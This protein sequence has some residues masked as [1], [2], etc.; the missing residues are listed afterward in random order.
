[1][2]KTI[3]TLRR[4]LG[5]FVRYRPRPA[6]GKKTW[7]YARLTEEVSGWYSPDPENK[8][9]RE[10]KF[11][12]FR[13]IGEIPRLSAESDV[14]EASKNFAEFEVS[15][16]AKDIGRSVTI[17]LAS[18]AEIKNRQFF[19]RPQQLHAVPAKKDLGDDG[20]QL[21]RI[22]GTATQGVSRVEP[23]YEDGRILIRDERYIT[24]SRHVDFAITEVMQRFG[25]SPQAVEVVPTV[26]DTKRM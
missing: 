25:V 14:H 16:L 9:R 8:D 13:G 5:N 4:H 2:S 12:G 21:C 10:E 3:E 7:E 22:W 6:R 18:H 1:M 15:F 23:A 17:E 19:G 26:F 24:C 20:C 11:I